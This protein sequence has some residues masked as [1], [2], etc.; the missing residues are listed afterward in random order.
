ME[1]RK[2]TEM[3]LL[4]MQMRNENENGKPEKRG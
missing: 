2:V 3:G 1:S 4:L